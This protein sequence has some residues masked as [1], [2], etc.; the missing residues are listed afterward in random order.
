MSREIRT[1]LLITC[2]AGIYTS[3][4]I[5]SISKELFKY[6]FFFCDSDFN[7]VERLKKVGKKIN[8]ISSAEEVSAEIYINEIKKLVNDLNIDYIIPF[9]DNE[10]IFL[11]SS[12]LASKTI[13]AAKDLATECSNKFRLLEFLKKN[14]IQT[15]NH[16]IINNNSDLDQLE[17]LLE[18]ESYCVKPLKGRGGKGFKRFSN[19]KNNNL[20]SN[21]SFCSPAIMEFNQF[22]RNFITDKSIFGKLICMNF[23][24]GYDFNID[25]SACEGKLIDLGIQRRDKPKFGPIMQGKVVRNRKIYEFIS[26]MIRKLKLTGVFN[27]ELVLETSK[28]IP[29][30]Y[31]INP[32][33][34]AGISFTEEIY[35]GF[36]SRAIDVLEKKN[37]DICTFKKLKHANIKREWKNQVDIQE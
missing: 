31:E 4:F 2:G 33:A 8:F 3:S 26:R 1:N 37:V 11:K 19:F 30:I 29:I 25:C 27:V 17:E 32:R 21:E 13:A 35:P 28:G 36:I 20:P 23:I 12:N 14:S 7:E 34:S 9:S 18:N 24:D 5:D 6:E 15:T 10:A 16:F 22:K